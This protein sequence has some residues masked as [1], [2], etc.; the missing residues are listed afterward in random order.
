MKQ[1]S[2]VPIRVLV[3]L[4]AA[5]LLCGTL[6]GLQASAANNEF[7]ASSQ[8]N[9]GLDGDDAGGDDL[10]FVPG[11]VIAPADSLEHAMTIAAAYG[12]ELAS[13]AY[14]IAI[15]IAP[16]PQEAVAQSETVQIMPAHS[17]SVSSLAPARGVTPLPQLSLNKIYHTFD[18][19]YDYSQAG[20][21]AYKYGGSAY[22]PY[23]TSY[24]A[25]T[26]SVTRHTGSAP[27]LLN[28]AEHAMQWHH[29]FMDNERA[30][31]L[32][33]GKNVVVA[34]IDTGIDIDH[35]D[36]AGRIS[37]KSYNSY[38]DQVGPEYVRDDFGHGTHV[39]GIVAGAL[40]DGEGV[41]GVAPLSEIMTVKANIPSDPGYFEQASWLR[42][43]NYAV[44]NGAQ[45]VNMSFGRLYFSG[46][47]S[48]EQ[49]V[50]ARAVANG[51]TVV[52]AAGNYD[53][54]YVSYPAAYEETIAVS[55]I[56]WDGRIDLSYSCYGPELDIAAPGTD[57][58]STV[59]GG[60]YEY[61]SG[62]S[63]ASPCAAGVAA[64]IV[65]LHPEYTPQQVRDALCQTARDT[66]ELGKDDYYGYG[67]VSS[68]GALL[69]PDKLLSVTFDYADGS[70]APVTVKTIPGE[71]LL[72]TYGPRRDGYAFT[73]WYIKG[74]QN[75][76]SFTEVI[77]EDLNL[78]A[79]WTEI[80]P[81]M[82][83]VEFPDVNFRREVLQLLNWDDKYRTD[84]SI[85][86]A[87]DAETLASF[88]YLYAADM[89]IGD[90]TGLSYFS[91]LETLLCGWNQLSELDLTKNTK[92]KAV[93][94]PFNQLSGL[95]V[96]KNTKL[97]E[98][99]CIF[100][101]IENLDVSA[102]IELEVLFCSFNQLH[103]LDVTK[104][105]ALTQF[106]CTYN[107]LTALDI[108]QNVA[109]E[110]LI[111]HENQLTALDVSNNAALWALDCG[112]NQLSALDL[113]K[114]SGLEW[115]YCAFN[116]LTALDVSHNA[117]LWYLTC[118]SNQLTSLDV[119]HNPELV[120][121]DCEENRLSTVD[122]SKNAAL[123][124]LYCSDNQ[125]RTLDLS[126]NTA[127]ELLYCGG[128]QLSTLDVSK[129][130]SL[131]YIYCGFN[132]LSALDVSK[133]TELA[134]LYCYNC[135]LNTLDLP[136]ST[137][138]LLVSCFS[139]R[140]TAFS[141]D[142]ATA[143]EYL[144]CYDNDLTA[145]DVAD[146]SELGLFDCRANKIESPDD[147][148]GWQEIGLILGD[149]FLFYPQKSDDIK[150]GAY[151]DAFPDAN[152]RDEVLNLL[153]Y[154]A[155]IK[156]TGESVMTWGDWLFLSS[157][158]YLDLQDM[159][160]R[161]MTGL[162]YFSGL[163]YLEC[164]WNQLSTLDVSANTAL[165][166]LHCS[167]NQ[168][169]ALDVSANTA[170]E[171][172]DCYD[173]Q[174]TK[175]DV[176]HN[177][178]LEYLGCG[179]NQLS[180]L[181]ISKNTVLMYLYCFDNQLTSL[182]ISRNIALESLH[183]GG[184]PLIDLD[185]SHLLALRSL[186][187]YDNQLTKLDATH[188]IALKELNCD[189]NQ[190]TA[191]D[192]S[193]NTALRYLY[194][195]DNQLSALDVSANTALVSLSC[196]YN[197]LDTL[198]VSKNAELMHLGCGGNELITLDVSANTALESLQCWGNQ[199][200]TLDISKNA[201]LR[202]LGC[203]YNNLTSLDVSNNNCLEYLY[204]NDNQLTALD[205]SH[206]SALVNLDCMHN[207]M[208]DPDSVRGWREVGLEINSLEDIYSGTFYFYPQADQDYDFTV[209][210][211]PSQTDLVV[212]DTLYVDV[213]I[214]G[215]LSY[216][217]AETKIA[218]DTGLLEFAGF[219]N[220][221]GWMGQTYREKPNFIITRIVPNINMN[222]GA[223]CTEPVRL[224]TLKFTVKDTLTASSIQTDLSFAV[225]SVF[226]PANAPLPSV[227]PGKD[228]NI[229]LY[230]K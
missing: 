65:S 229:T 116:Q 23:R 147:V 131:W 214:S 121:L 94:C 100:N 138:L 39:S 11:E 92:L 130:I 215:R 219:E 202:D 143:L 227:A 128:N 49:A 218:Y 228:L 194:C 114:N 148:S 110:E 182:D 6:T 144:W 160:I 134:Y 27:G 90:M 178:A 118:W 193:K 14:G 192:V 200:S 4:L 213:M 97:L 162:S 40:N 156:R 71:K 150:L 173:N 230:H 177:I 122:L 63:M 108:S 226:P 113:T 204:C 199:L 198:D 91:G 19:T 180:A 183:C 54:G 96:S 141:A 25:D 142:S 136:E 184:N 220:M 48:L 46:P 101:Q 153:Y 205:V 18:V 50:I 3:L 59:M 201:F 119:S 186:A 165:E 1:L 181:D 62:T 98:L 197:L 107:Q 22:E 196:D 74:T 87:A 208:T 106:D 137:N 79:G 187:C 35:P 20:E 37:A 32:S 158:E 195:W 212:G 13:Y 112:D 34:V 80:K 99:G 8:L 139:N 7:D 45:V 164:G 172:L 12:L 26:Y 189:N 95:D 55:A 140:L 70:R 83:I 58:Y 185:V 5:V 84:G 217:L 221:T 188:N 47:D 73:G 190:I 43:L 68:Y 171:Y 17:M 31:K 167:G 103:K 72:E 102:N 124:T 30:W 203:G 125:L 60:G 179:Y 28:E 152:F 52:C 82:Y 109:L 223:Y 67:I 41:C 15:F 216:A 104:N 24:T 105:S 175:L 76:F 2:N 149:S 135:Q 111:C 33:A 44:D 159:D 146:N 207:R 81:G 69:G 145:L 169:T 174:L 166:Y 29:D 161:D 85:I 115:V 206:N 36:F 75:R 154:N 133:N 88:E 56:R 157:M 222:V 117:A 126:A 51:V 61:W 211:E 64:L 129:N 66:G 89:L 176:T 53:P 170:L 57:I 151:K 120:Y 77:T 163:E 224:V 86:D 132:P 93:D 123:E 191:L 78:Y 127:L 210:M 225:I 21:T 9:L 10:V 16:D 38:T 155:G 168:L 42:G 209:Y